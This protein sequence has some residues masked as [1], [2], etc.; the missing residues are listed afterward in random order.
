MIYLIL[1]ELLLIVCTFCLAGE[2]PRDDE[3]IAA[4]QERS[5]VT[6]SRQL[7]GRSVTVHVLIQLAQLDLISRT[8]IMLLLLSGPDYL[9]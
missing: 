2:L 1:L 9:L 6:A 3:H 5:A 8:S 4:E 7:Q